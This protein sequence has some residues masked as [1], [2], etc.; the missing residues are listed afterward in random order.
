MEKVYIARCFW[1]VAEDGTL[2]LDK[3]SVFGTLEEARGFIDELSDPDEDSSFRIEIVAYT[4]GS[5]QSWSDEQIWYFDRKGKLIRKFEAGKTLPPDQDRSF[6]GKYKKGEIVLA[7]AFPFNEYSSFYLDTI[8][9]I[10]W[11][12]MPFREWTKMGK[13]AEEWTNCYTVD[14]ITRFGFLTHDHIHEKSIER[15]SAQVAKE[16]EFLNI[17]SDH[18]LGKRHIKD[19]VLKDLYSSKMFVKNVRAF[20]ESDFEK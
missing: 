15:Y 4:L 20:T 1:I 2:V 8:G 3:E 12:P 9:V 17:L 16:L 13:D 10:A 6:T 19:E 7:R 5:H 11:V 18:Y 14:Y